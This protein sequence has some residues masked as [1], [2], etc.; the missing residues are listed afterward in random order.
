VIGN[1][2][3]VFQ[4]LKLDF[5]HRPDSSRYNYRGVPS[6]LASSARQERTERARVLD[7]SISLEQIED[8]FF[9]ALIMSDCSFLWQ[10]HRR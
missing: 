2:S 8:Q 9:L 10:C 1:P 6:Y 3:P 4:T 7:V 5:V